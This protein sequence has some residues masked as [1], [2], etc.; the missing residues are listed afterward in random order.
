MS[1]SEDKEDEKPFVVVKANNGRATC[2]HCK[3]KCPVGKWRIA[4]VGFNPFGAGKM[5]LWHHIKCLFKAFLNQRAE[6]RRIEAPEDIQGWELLDEDLQLYIL[7]YVKK[8]DDFHGNVTSTSPRRKPKSKEGNIDEESVS[9]T[10]KDTKTMNKS[11]DDIKKPNKYESFKEF[12]KLVADIAN[13]DSRQE[14]S[15][16]LEKFAKAFMDCSKNYKILW[17]QLLMPSVI[18]YNFEYLNHNRLIKIFSSIFDTDKNKILKHLNQESD[19]GDTIAYFFDKNTTLAPAKKSNLTVTDVNDFLSKLDNLEEEDKIVEYFKNF[20]VKCT[21]ND[22]VTVIHIIEGDLQIDASP[23]LILTT[24][25]KNAYKLYQTCNDIDCVLSKFVMGNS[26]VKINVLMN[27]NLMVPVSPMLA[28]ECKLLEDVFQKFPNGVYAEIMYSGDRVQIHKSGNRFTYFSNDLKEI[29]LEKIAD[30]EKYMY[31]AFPFTKDFIID[32]ELVLTEKNS[33]I[34]IRLESVIEQDKFKSVTACFFA[35]DCLYFGEESLL[36]KPLCERKNYLKNDIKE[37][38]NHVL[39]SE[40][41]K[42]YQEEDCTKIIAEVKKQKFNGIIFKDIKG[43]YESQTRNWLKIKRKNLFGHNSSDEDSDNLQKDEEKSSMDTPIR[44]KPNIRRKSIVF[45]ADE[46]Q[47][48]DQDENVLNK[49]TE[50]ETGVNSSISTNVEQNTEENNDILSNTEQEP[51]CVRSG[52]QSPQIFADTQNELQ[53]Q[54][55]DN[56]SESEPK[57]TVKHH[58]NTSDSNK[59]SSELND[60]TGKSNTDKDKPQGNNS[61][62]TSGVQLDVK[63][64]MSRLHSPDSFYS[65]ENAERST[66]T[67]VKNIEDENNVNTNNKNPAKSDKDTEEDKGSYGDGVNSVEEDEIAVVKDKSV[68]QNED[69]HSEINNDSDDTIAVDELMTSDE[70]P[71]ESEKTNTKKSLKHTD[72]INDLLKKYSSPKSG[73]NLDAGRENNDD[74][75]DAIIIMDEF[76]NF[77]QSRMTRAKKPLK[78]TESDNIHDTDKIT[79]CESSSEKNSPTNSLKTGETDTELSIVHEENDKF[80][81]KSNDKIDSINSEDNNDEESVNINE[82]ESVIELD[83]TTE[84]T[85][86]K[87]L[88]HTESDNINVA[89]HCES[90]SEKNSSTNNLKSGKKA[91]TEELSHVHEETDNISKSKS[92]DQDDSINSGDNNDEE[93]INIIELDST[94]EHDQTIESSSQKSVEYT[95]LDKNNTDVINHSESS[96]EKKSLTKNLKSGKNADTEELINVHEETDKI[97][98]TKSN[99]QDDSI[100]SEDNNDEESSNISELELTFEIDETIESSTQK[101]PEHTESDNINHIDVTNLCESSSEKNSS[102]NNLKSGKNADTQEL[103]NVDEE[104]D[105]NSTNINNTKKCPTDALTQKR[106]NDEKSNDFDEESNKSGNT[107]NEKQ[108]SGLEDKSDRPID[109]QDQHNTVTI[110]LSSNSDHERVHSSKSQKKGKIDFSGS[111]SSSDEENYKSNAKK[112]QNIFSS[113]DSD[114]SE[115]GNSKS[116]N[117]NK[118]GGSNISRKTKTSRIKRA[119][120]QILENDLQSSDNEVIFKKNQRGQSVDSGRNKRKQQFSSEDEFGNRSAKFSKTTAASRR[121][122]LESLSTE[123]DENVINSKCGSRKELRIVL[124]D[125]LKYTKTQSKLKDQSVNN[126]EECKVSTRKNIKKP[127][128]VSD[129]D[130]THS[131]SIFQIENSAEGSDKIRKNTKTQNEPKSKVQSVNNAKVSKVSS[132]KG[133]ERSIVISDTNSKHSSSTLEKENGA[134]GSDQIEKVASPSAMESSQKRKASR[135]LIVLVNKLSRTGREESLDNNPSASTIRS[136]NINEQRLNESQNKRTRE[137]PKITIGTPSSKRVRNDDVESNEYNSDT[138]GKRHSTKRTVGTPLSKRVRNDDVESDEYNSDTDGKRHSTKRTVGTPLSKRVR[139]DDV[140]SD[141]YNS[142][143]DGVRCTSPLPI[144]KSNLTMERDRVGNWGNGEHLVPGGVSG[145]ERLTTPALNKG[146]AFTFEERQQLGIHGLL[147]PVVKSQEQQI[148]HCKKCLDRLDDN[149]NKYMYLIGLLDRNEKLFY[150]FVRKYVTDIMPL[151]YTPVVGLACQN[152]GLVYRRPRGMYVTIYDKGNVYEIMKNWPETDVRAIVVTDGERILGLGDQGACGMGIPVGK[153]SLYTALAGI[154]P[155]QCLPITIDV[156]TNNETHLKDPLYIGL[157]QKRVTGQEYDELL[158]EFMEAV[159]RR[160]GQNTLIQFED[161]GNSNAFRLLEK[162]R[163]EYC[164]FNDDIQGTASVAVAGLL[165]S[166]RITKTRLSDH[167]I[168]FQGAGEA[169]LG[170][171]QLCTMAMVK[172]GT[173]ESDARKKI[174][175][176]DS[177]GLIVKDRPEGGINHHKEMYAHAHPPVKTLTEV[178]KSIKPSILIGAAAIGGAFTSEILREMA[179]NNKRPVIFALSNPTHKAEC[180]AEEC[181]RETNGTAIFASGSPFDPVTL[182]GKTFYP[183]QGNNSYIFPGVGLATVTAGIQKISEEHFLVAAEALANLV[184]EDNLENGRIYPPLESIVAC[185]L[186]IATRLLEYAYEEGN[187]T[188]LPEPKDKEAF[189]KAQMYNTDYQ[190]ALPAVYAFPKL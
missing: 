16:C 140:E 181:Y 6:T 136:V 5:K 22:L 14:K 108:L 24:I 163:N 100:N 130:S 122:Q 176:V 87:S 126:A 125:V 155:H 68:N 134:E 146:L 144:N 52:T 185:S 96:T 65:V 32:G 76:E 11:K 12:R 190:P 31:Q 62:E 70:E 173:S 4:K 158:D 129:T 157:R 164:T 39:Y 171:A 114:N 9:E 156:G 3:E 81:T 132:T 105:M 112:R 142:D 174:W 23:R 147:P 167:V 137:S 172:E 117:K 77:V 179:K 86:Q 72:K 150:S 149:L 25:D 104:N 29:Q 169:N 79:D 101:S 55:K 145:L 159:V 67:C 42:V 102:T 128:V 188:V 95:K 111:S 98:K 69:N 97:S 84:S 53:L 148:E 184:T 73:E 74:E 166:L 182:N 36:Q 20:L 57:E 93:S 59:S 141:E 131:S 106:K 178:V 116:S 66:P 186:R 162:Y 28:E 133:I 152:F 121:K 103:S 45:D 35:F 165:A 99:D 124:T 75:E 160:W 138:D 49:S 180:T 38:P 109:T 119:V 78:P 1:D 44:H 161:F 168:V 91:D 143:V 154:K 26:Q 17:Y 187:A 89:E 170:I 118:N 71:I 85:S 27:K 139:N 56:D 83:Q 175:M 82:L 92:N 40:M 18:R 94:I 54:E 15:K 88:G 7:K 47:N 123:D 30:F 61:S 43:I 183:G 10:Q 153:L 2:K 13:T 115:E 46:S 64:E 8:L 63:D 120:I 34:P 113:E 107:N 37:I 189:I 58:E 21:V 48:E 33:K 151:V 127:I 177:K 19:I 110:D 51:K 50:V 41:K 60:E 135:E 80:K 90:S